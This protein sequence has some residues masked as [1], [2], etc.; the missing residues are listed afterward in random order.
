MTGRGR[1]W[2]R[3]ALGSDK[4][5]AKNQRKIAFLSRQIPQGKVF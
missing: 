1:I 4:A 3:K 2:V 5:W